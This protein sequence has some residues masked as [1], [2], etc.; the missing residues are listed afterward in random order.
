MERLNHYIF[1][2]RFAGKGKS[3]VAAEGAAFCILD[4]RGCG[5]ADADF[6]RMAFAVFIVHTFLGFTVHINRLTAAALG[7]AGIR[8]CALPE[9]FTAGFTGRLGVFAS[10]HD[11]AFG[12]ELILVVDA[13]YCRTA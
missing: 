9:A 7:V 3:A 4:L 12:A 8:G 2:G 13:G 10:Y 11:V 5:A 1:C 6:G